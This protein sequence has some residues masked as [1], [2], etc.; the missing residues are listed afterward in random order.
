MPKVKRLFI[1]IEVSPNIVLAF[2]AGY[3]QTIRPESIILE[4]KIICIG[5][6]WEGERKRTVIRWDK[7]QDDTKLLK[8]FA[9]VSKEADE[10][11]AHFGDRYDLPFIR[12]RCLIL[13]LDPLPL[14]KTIDTKA[15]ASKYFYFNSN[16]L[17]YIS[18]VLGYA[19]K[20][21]MELDDWRDILMRN[22]PKKLNK[23]CH[24][25]GIDVVRLE[26]VYHKMKHCVKPKSHTGVMMGLE[27]WTCPWD[28]SKNVRLSKTRVTAAGTV[29]RQMVCL[30]CKRYYVITERA[31]E[32]FKLSKIRRAAK[33]RD[34]KR[35]G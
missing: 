32:D 8:Q 7:D 23:M 35:R 29:Q 2:R 27:K 30:D 17:D 5:F 6:K 33:K 26:Q 13:G 31:Y 24:Y 18:K 19:G 12:T 1:D 14:Y 20:E 4:R 16:K 25:C 9:A 15:W 21:K 10:I 34:S 3:E 11:I 28:G 22:D